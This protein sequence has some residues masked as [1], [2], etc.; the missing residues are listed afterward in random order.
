M[1][2][3]LLRSSAAAFR[4]SFSTNFAGSE[5]P[6]SESG[7]WSRTD[8]NSTKVIKSS[9]VAIGTQDGL[10]GFNDSQATVTG[11]DPTARLRAEATIFRSGSISSENHEVELTF[12]SVETSTTTKKYEFLVNKNG[13]IAFVKWLGGHDFDQFQVISIDSGFNNMP[14]PEDG[15]IL[16]GECE[17]LSAGNVEL[18]LWRKLPSDPDFVAIATA[19]DDGS[20]GGAAYESGAPGIG[21]YITSPSANPAHFGFTDYSVTTF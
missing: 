12:R 3:F 16:R 21:F 6:L 2:V 19:L 20:I 7:D 13:D 18:R 8:A 17:T 11:F 4:T 9:G 10:G 14:T 1:P 5:D 15:T